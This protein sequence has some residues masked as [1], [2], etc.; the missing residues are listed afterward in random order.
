[1]DA[2]THSP[3]ALFAVQA[4]LIVVSSRLI[5]LLAKRVDQPMVIAEVVAGILLGPSLLGW[6]LP[7]VSAVLFPKTSLA[8]LGLVAQIGLSLFMFLVGLELDPKL[9]RG[10]GHASVVISHSSIVAPFAL[11]SLL[12]LYLYPRLADPGVRFSAF[13]LFMGSAMSITAF[14]VLARILGERR[15]LRSKI[16]ALTITCAAV[17][18]VTA[19]C[20]LAFVVA[21]V[22]TTGMLAAL[23]TTLLAVGYILLMLKGVQPLLRRLGAR[24]ST[25]EGLTQNT[26]ALT[27]VLLFLSSLATELIGIHALFGAFLLGA[28][29]PKEGGFA[30][31]LAEK[32][33]DLVV[34]L[35]L[36]MFFAY[37]GLRTQIGLLNT[38][39]SWLMCALIIAVACLGKF[40]GGTLAARA[41][42]LKWR[43]ASA[44]GILMNTR[45][46]ME[47][48]VLNIGLD[49]GVISPKL[50]AMMVIMALVT[51]FIT[52]PLLSWVYPPTELAKELA[53]D[54]VEP[55]EP[56][57]P[58]A[59]APQP[60]FTVLMCV[61]LDRSGP[62]MVTVAGALCG[63]EPGRLYALRL[64]RASERSSFQL[65][66]AP[67]KST[68]GL[69]PLLGRASELGLSIRPLS[70]VS[71][72]PGR[73]IVDVAAVKQADLIVLGWH[74]PLISGNALGGTVR[75]VMRDATADVGVLVDRGL[76]RIGRVLVPYL[77]A[78]HDRAAL[79]LAQRL[80]RAGAELTILHV[81]SAARSGQSR[82][83]QGR[84]SIEEIFR[85][86]SDAPAESESL[87]ITLKAAEGVTPAEAALA[88]AAHGYDLMI[89]G[90][91]PEWG[92]EQR[93]LRTHSEQIIQA[94]PTSLL[95]VKGR[96]TSP[97]SAQSTK[98]PSRATPAS[99]PPSSVPPSS[100]PPSS[101]TPA[102]TET[103]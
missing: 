98:T 49:L 86:E 39:E 69:V 53:E 12:A 60:A 94:C 89:V 68:D 3:I 59:P 84:A 15:L 88:E 93:S 17:D 7:G 29:I 58:V 27:L 34:V 66:Q 103:R 20:I 64:L 70:F 56:V 77:G 87:R 102:S 91:G 65:Q 21:V 4:V 5:G 62:G 51:T 25:R 50:F 76:E 13:T 30:T 96:S 47:L 10:R 14:P 36:P 19:W 97:P 26:V 44:I 72:H 33:E 45:G 18:D 81:V 79:L 92:L 90:V 100:T 9:L 55:V 24:S 85:G 31:T 71:A 61:S 32:L 63:R 41:V 52:T 8:A 80:H 28:I 101:A 22:R 83:S 23:K 43:E 78:P 1:M 40:G 42:G 74:K 46:L 99:V 11:G 54:A 75:E 16:G 82:Q 67:T 35:L 38:P 95:V 6:L 48:V 37:S 57:A 2:L 73:D